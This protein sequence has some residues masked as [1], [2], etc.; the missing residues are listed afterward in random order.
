[1]IYRPPF[2]LTLIS[3]G[4]LKKPDSKKTVVKSD[5]VYRVYERV[6]FTRQEAVDAVEALFNEIKSVLARREDV[7][8]SNFGSFILKD[9]K[10]RKARNPKTGELI[11]IR[12]RRVLT[13][14]PSKILLDS[15]NGTDDSGNS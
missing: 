9:K 8:L 11:R 15:T 3:T 5:L 12:A 4:I 14:K 6:G 7:R 10:A 1:M 13:F 2:S